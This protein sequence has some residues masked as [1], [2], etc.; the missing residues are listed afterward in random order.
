MGN[1]HASASHTER[2]N[3]KTVGKEVTIIAVLGDGQVMGESNSS[4]IKKHA[5]LYFSCL[6][7][8]VFLVFSPIMTKGR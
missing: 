7:M 5:L 4:D 8:V 6:V 2:R 3:D 1:G